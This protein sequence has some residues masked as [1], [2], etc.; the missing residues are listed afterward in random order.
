MYYVLWLSSSF[1]S[2]SLPLSLQRF[3]STFN[4]FSEKTYIHMYIY[5]VLICV[6]CAMC[7]LHT[8]L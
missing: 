5:I 8:E 7:G 2:N 3:P 4:C 6:T 1:P